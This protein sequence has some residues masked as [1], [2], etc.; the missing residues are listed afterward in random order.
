MLLRSL[1]RLASALW[2]PHAEG[3]LSREIAS[4][5][6]LLEDAF[7]RRRL[8]PDDALQYPR[9]LT[10]SDTVRWCQTPCKG[11]AN[12]AGSAL[13]AVFTDPDLSASRRPEG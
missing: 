2:P 4:H 11:P 1:R 6:A 7:R 3:D 8:T 9:C 5:L 10:P 12:S 13:I